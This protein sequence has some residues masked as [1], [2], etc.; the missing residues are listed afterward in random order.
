MKFNPP[1]WA[2]WIAQESNGDWWHYENKPI[3]G[4]RRWMPTHGNFVYSHKT[5]PVKNWREQL[6]KIEWRWV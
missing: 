4:F 1:K 6:Y 2:R 3:S 5:K